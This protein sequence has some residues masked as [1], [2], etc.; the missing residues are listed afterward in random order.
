MEELEDEY[1]RIFGERADVSE[2]AQR[3]KFRS[4]ESVPLQIEV[5]EHNIDH[6]VFRSWCPHC[7]KG[8]ASS[9]GHPRNENDKGDIPKVCIDYMYMHS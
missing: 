1:E 6:A 9:Y 5:D 2:E 7:V 3:A 4:V 8:K